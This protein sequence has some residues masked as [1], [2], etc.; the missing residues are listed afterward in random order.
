MPV[1]A[2]ALKMP[3]IK[4]QLD[5]RLTARKATIKDKFFIGIKIKIVMYLNIHHYFNFNARC[6]YFAFAKRSETASQFTT[7]I[8]AAT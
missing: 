5:K 1:Y 3:V 4:S 8:N 6:N 2:P 7:F